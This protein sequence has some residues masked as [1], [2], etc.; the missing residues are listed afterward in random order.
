MAVSAVSAGSLPNTFVA[1]I[2][3]L[4]AIHVHDA[5]DSCHSCGVCVICHPLDIETVRAGSVIIALD[6]SLLWSAGV[7]RYHR[8]PIP[9]PTRQFHPH[10]GGL[11]A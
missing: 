2:L 6:V 3:H 10:D 8:H 11:S 4:V 9:Q 1:D 7:R 5:V